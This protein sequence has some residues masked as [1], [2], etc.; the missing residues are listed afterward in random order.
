VNVGV[1]ASFERVAKVV[2]TLRQSKRCDMSQSRQGYP[3]RRPSLK[4]GL[5]VLAFIAIVAGL[6][7]VGISLNRYLDPFDDQPFAQSAW[8]SADTRVRAP[9]ARDAIRRLPTGM[10]ADQVQALLGRPTPVP[11]YS[12]EVDAYGNHL[13]YPETWFYYLGSWSVYGLDDAFLYV[14]FDSD[15]KVALVEITGG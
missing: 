11:R 14:H 1:K 6:F 15:K 10:T 9:M 2:E 5:G 8:A 12:G 4:R 7:I 13:K 3:L